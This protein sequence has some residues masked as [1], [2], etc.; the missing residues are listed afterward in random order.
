LFFYNGTTKLKLAANGNAT[1]AG[2]GTFTSDSSTA[3]V[4]YLEAGSSNGN[5]IQFVKSGTNKWEVVGRDG[6]F[7]VYKNDGTGS[8][9]KWQINTSGEHTFTGNAT[10]AGTVTVGTGTVAAAN[11][12]ADDFVITGPGTTAT[13]MTIS[14]SSDAGTGTIFFG[15]T[16][17]SSV[18]GFRY[19][20]NTG[21][22]AISAEDN[23][24]FSCDN[25]GIGATSP[26]EKL[27]IRETSNTATTRIKIE[28]GSYGF[29][30]GKTTQEANYAHLRPRSNSPAVFRIMPNVGPNLR[31][32][33]NSPAVFRIMPNVGPN[34]SYMEIWGT[35]YESN[36]TNY[37]RLMFYINGSTG[38]ANIK[39]NKAGSSPAGSLYIGTASSEQAIT[40]L[41]S[42]NVGIGTTGPLEPLSIFAGTNE[43]VYDVLGVY[44]TVTGTSAINKGA[45]IRIGIGVDGS[46]STKI[47]TIYEG[48]NPNYL[49]PALAFYTMYNTSSK[50]SETEKMRISANGNV[51]IGF[52]GPG[53]SP[54]S[55]FKLSV[56]GNAY[57]SGDV[58]IGTTNPSGKFHVKDGSIDA[59]VVTTCGNVGIKTTS[60]NASLVVKGNVSYGYNNYSSVANTWSNA[61]NFSGYPAGLYQVNICKQS[62][63]SAYIIAQVKWSGTAGTV[64]NTVTSVQYGITFS[65]TQLQSIINTTTASSIS[66]QC[67][68][69]Y[70]LACV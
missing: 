29:T 51:G 31:P 70:E 46:Y 55:S 59:L 43:S 53:A 65:G 67:L 6:T 33:S 5:I 20:H 56:N 4:L 66:V 57:I 62:N 34:Y 64:I 68:V 11:A 16:T 30:L 50:G 48:N 24:T 54:L 49:Q 60:P 8:G 45:A 58:G 35:D 32:R 38:D 28:G 41:N 22:M 44:N 23:I 3:R 12:A 21:D 7:Y 40:I 25:V 61:L 27:V 37:N 17:S 9:Y 15:D 69:T 13:G 14:N 26:N 18:A 2:S 10:F 42:G 47:A 52:T 1:F 39:I 63:A 36:T 19:N